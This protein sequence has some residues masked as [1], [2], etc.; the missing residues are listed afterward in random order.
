MVPLLSSILI[1]L[2]T[3]LVNGSIAELYIDRI[4][5]CL[6]K[7]A[8]SAHDTPL[9]F[10]S[11]VVDSTKNCI[12]CA[13]FYEK[14]HHLCSI[15]RK[16]AS[17][18]L[19]STKN[20]ITCARFYEKL[21][22]LCSILRKTASLVLDSTKNCITCARFYEKLHHLCSILRKAASFYFRSRSY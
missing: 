3:V 16:T 21:H 9:R 15:L 10:A 6:K 19:D 13:R 2:I 20:C 22:H 7:P 5:S 8:A 12:T 14:L 18:V 4:N 11:L 17:L 1:E